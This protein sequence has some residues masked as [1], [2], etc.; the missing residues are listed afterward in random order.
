MS[1]YICI[2]ISYIVRSI[3]PRWNQRCDTQ[4][5]QKGNSIKELPTEN[6]ECFQ[7]C[8]KTIL[9]RGRNPEEPLLAVITGLVRFGIESNRYWGWHVQV[10]IP[11]QLQHNVTAHQPKWLAIGDEP[12][13]RRPW[14]IRFLLARDLMNVQARS[15]AE[16]FPYQGR[17]VQ[18]RQHAVVHYP[19]ERVP[20]MRTRVDRDVYPIAPYSIK[21]GD[22]PV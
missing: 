7:G 21:P 2:P 19:A 13:A 1:T 3:S 17:S 12:V 18:Y 6:E 4:L 5:S 8:T 14:I 20:S 22:G 16:H 9:R 11:M 10:Q 15:I